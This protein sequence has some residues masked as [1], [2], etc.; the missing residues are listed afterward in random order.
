MAV[1]PA[2]YAQVNWRFTGSGVPSGAETTLGLNIENYAGTPS[3]L[4]L[5]MAQAW[6]TAN[7]D[8][9]QSSDVALT[10]VLVKFGPT[11]TGPSAVW[12]TNIPG[13]NTTASPSQV[14]YLANK[15]TGLGGRQGK[16]RMYI[17]GVPEAR[18]D[19]GGILTG[20]QQGFLQTALDNLHAFLLTNDLLPVLLRAP[21]SPIQVPAPV[22]SFTAQSK[23]ATQRRRLRR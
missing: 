5:L 13:T 21:D 20:G 7:M 1:I 6:D 10:S 3:Q 2:S 17:P 16:G 12:A 8:G 22:I 14:A 11:A 9:N 19:Q 15:N 18:V 4:G 23:V